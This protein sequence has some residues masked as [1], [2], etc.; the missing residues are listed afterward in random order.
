MRALAVSRTLVGLLAVI[1]TVSMAACSNGSGTGAVTLPTYTIGGTLTGLA[2]GQSVTLLDNNVNSLPVSANGSFT[3]STSVAAG[4]S[5]SVTVA[6]EPGGQTCSVANGSGGSLAANVTS[7]IVTCS[8][9]SNG[10]L[11]LLAGTRTDREVWMA[12]ARRRVSVT[13]SGRPWMVRATSM[14][15]TRATTRSARSRRREW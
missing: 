6:T 5:Y 8:T 14:W 11:A 7:V 1:T 13:R 10:V 3:F 12:R 4:G 2:S 9:Y 15:R